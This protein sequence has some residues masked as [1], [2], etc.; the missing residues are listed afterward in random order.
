MQHIDKHTMPRGGLRWWAA[1]IATAALL[2]AAGAAAR[3]AE[4]Q[5]RSEIHSDGGLVLL[6]DVAD[7]RSADSAEQKQLAEIDVVPAPPAGERRHLRARELQDILAARGVNLRQHR[8][9]G[10]AQVTIIGTLEQAPPRAKLAV[11]PKPALVLPNP[12]RATET[13]HKAL[14]EY[15]DE[16][17]ARTADWE[18]KFELGPAQVQAVCSAPQSLVVSGGHEPWTGP[19]TFVLTI[20][21]DGATEQTNLRA[22]VTLPPT[23]VVATRSLPRG[24]L[25]HAD[26]VRLQPG[27]ASQGEAH[28]YLSVEDVVNKEVVKTVIEGQV[29]DDVSVRRPVLVHRGEIVTVYARSDGVQVRTT[30]RSRDDGTHNDLVAVESLAERK[31]IFARV[32]GPQEVEVYAHA[33]PVAAD[34]AGSPHDKN[35]LLSG[36]LAPPPVRACGPTRRLRRRY[37][38]M[39]GCS[40][41]RRLPRRPPNQRPPPTARRLAASWRRPP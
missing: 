30:A 3:A 36:P 18:T 2:V 26:D 20:T 16:R 11:A 7:V 8:L 31:P 21:V 5:L 41:M 4:I 39:S 15:L 1:P 33:V 13:V 38:G 12:R 34:V 19:Q 37:P 10:A 25:V 17:A 9:S 32:V 23:V 14:V 40:K 24:T 27:K 22:Q 28:V 35:G 6:G 29:L